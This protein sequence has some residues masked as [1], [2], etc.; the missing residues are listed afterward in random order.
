VAI[1]PQ[2]NPQEAVGATITIGASIWIPPSM[3]GHDRSEDET[4]LWK[5]RAHGN[6]KTISTG[7]WKSRAEREIPTFPQ[8]ASSCF[9]LKHIDDERT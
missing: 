4:R 2:P 6:H 9:V 3:V 1:I 5:W 7:A 8:A